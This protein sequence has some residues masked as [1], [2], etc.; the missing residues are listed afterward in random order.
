MRQ[1][2]PPSGKKEAGFQRI[3]VGTRRSVA[4]PMDRIFFTP[5]ALTPAKTESALGRVRRPKENF[6]KLYSYLT[7]VGLALVPGVSLVGVTLADGGLVERMT[8][9]SEL[10]P[11]FFA[12]RNS[13]LEDALPFWAVGCDDDLDA[14]GL[15]WLAGAAARP[16]LGLTGASAPFAATGV[17]GEIRTARPK[18]LSENTDDWPAEAVLRIGAAQPAKRTGNVHYLRS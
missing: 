4:E 11:Q 13:L 7:A 6:A 10:L 5:M 8:G 2:H 18:L 17:A 1:D 14:S 15:E 3:R 16:Y 9:K 12:W